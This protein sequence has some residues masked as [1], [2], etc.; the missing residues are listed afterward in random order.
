MGDL[1]YQLHQ[2]LGAHVRTC[3]PAKRILFQEAVTAAYR[4][5]WSITWKCRSC[6]RMAA[7]VSFR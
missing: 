7:S 5:S 6:A 3:A 4:A 2:L 1:N